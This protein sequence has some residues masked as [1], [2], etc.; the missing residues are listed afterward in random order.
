MGLKFRILLGVV[1]LFG[2]FV[3]VVLAEYIND[4][5]YI[6]PL[7]IDSVQGSTVFNNPAEMAHWNN[8]FGLELRYRTPVNAFSG[9]L[10]FKIPDFYLGNFAFSMEAFGSDFGNNLIWVPKT[11]EQDAHFSLTKGGQKY[12][13]TWGKRV[14][15]VT[16]GADVKY[17][18]YRELAEAGGVVDDELGVGFDLG[19]LYHPWEKFFLGI[20]ISDF[21]D[22]EI[23][24]E[25]KNQLG[26]IQERIQLTAAIQPFADLSLSVAAPVDILSD[27][28]DDRDFLRKMSFSVRKIWDKG[29]NAEI[30]YNSKDIYAGLGYIISD[31]VNIKTLLSNDLSIKDGQYEALFQVSAVLPTRI[32]TKISSGINR[33]RQIVVGSKTASKPWDFLLNL[34]L[35]INDNLITRSVYLDNADIDDANDH[36]SDM[37]S[38]DGQIEIDY[39]RNRLIV[40]DFRQNVQ[41][42]V[43]AVRRYDGLGDS[44]W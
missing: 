38:T 5:F 16:F 19:I 4:T 31:A 18:R 9:T 24:D 34:W 30:G 25:D 20:V 3:N 14:E 37:L 2:V 33:T 44:D 15:Q 32:W 39:R 8:I 17:Y 42:I 22:T 26:T 27:R 7:Y 35:G 23:F 13:F 29:L 43:E 41:D 6:S 21:T 36:V 10:T 28:V 12:V 1:V 11:S 40:T